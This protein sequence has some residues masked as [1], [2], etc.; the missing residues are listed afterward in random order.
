MFDNA[1]SRLGKT[2]QPKSEEGQAAITDLLSST[3]TR[4]LLSSCAGCDAEGIEG[5]GAAGIAPD[6]P[7]L[8]ERPGMLSSNGGGG[9]GAAI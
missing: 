1:G 7:E 4:A 6:N 2:L 3:F 8:E 9:G 5:G